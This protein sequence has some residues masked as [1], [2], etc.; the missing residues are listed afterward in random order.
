MPNPDLIPTADAAQILGCHVRTVHRFV[1]SG[2]LK[3]AVRMPGLRGALM[4][5]RADVERLAKRRAA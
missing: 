1:E 5:R 2:D 4:F 3:P